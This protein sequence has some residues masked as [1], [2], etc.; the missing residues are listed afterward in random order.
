MSN[1]S[2]KYDP[3]SLHKINEI[4]SS[5]KDNILIDYVKDLLN[6]IEYQKQRIKEQEE[7]IIAIKHKI[8]WKHYDRPLNEYDTVKRKYI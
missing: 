2:L 1:K 3:V 5:N 6:L 7:T 8:A 4:L